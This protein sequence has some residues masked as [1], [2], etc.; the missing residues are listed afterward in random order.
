M[1]HIFLPLRLIILF[2]DEYIVHIHCQCERG[3]FIQRKCLSVLRKFM[4]IALHIFR[5]IPFS[6]PLRFPFR[7]PFSVLVTPGFLNWFSFWQ[8]NHILQTLWVN[9]ILLTGGFTSSR[10]NKCEWNP[11]FVDCIFFGWGLAPY[12][13]RNA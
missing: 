13:I 10:V 5:F 12:G 3:W 8:R 1:F 6:F 4:N 2:Y 11:L 9:I 7:F